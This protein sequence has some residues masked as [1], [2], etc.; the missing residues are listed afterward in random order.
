MTS[1]SFRAQGLTSLSPSRLSIRGLAATRVSALRPLS[2][3]AIRETRP[4]TQSSQ[5]PLPL[6]HS[7]G[8]AKQEGTIAS[9]FA[10]LSGGS[11]DDKLPPRF[12]ELKKSMVRDDRHK[13]ALKQAWLDVLSRLERRVEETK[14][15]G[16]KTIPEVN[17]PGDANIL[18]PVSEWVSAENLEQIKDRGVVVVKGVVP[19][20]QALRWK[21]EIREYVNRN[22]QVKGFPEDNPQVYELYWSKPQLEA[23][24]NH[25]LLQT[26][27]TFLS[28]FHAPSQGAG[29]SSSGRVSPP[30]LSVSLSNPLT[31]ADRLRIRLP[32]DSKFALG[33]HIDGGG[34]E[35]WECETFRGVWSSILEGGTGWARHD[36]WSLGPSAERLGAKTDMYGGPGQCAVFRPLQGW[37]SMSYTRSNEGTLRVLPFLKES[38][39]YIIL[40]PFFSPKKKRSKTG[41]PTVVIAKEDISEEEYLSAENWEFDSDSSNFPGCSLGHNIELSDSTHPHLRLGE[42]MTSIP[43]VE[44]GDMVLW[45]C[46][47]VHSVEARH[48]GKGDSS[49]MYIP[50]IPTTKVN[51]DYVLQ[52]SRDFRRGSPP[53][54]FPG[55]QGE[56]YFDGRG[57]PEDIASPMARR[58]MAL[59]KFEIQD[60]MSLAE[61]NLLD[62]CNALIR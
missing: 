39:A 22:P 8:S 60:G 36:P 37:L 46:D 43:K 42:T 38:T 50:A 25:A 33:P 40:R 54:D 23:R 48:C 26:S 20:E 34:V 62:Y 51:F 55:G 2:T 31:Y 6:K 11:L 5:A 7:N 27:R 41:D 16:P 17:Y 19:Q 35:R 45:H 29:A 1:V 44:P 52:Q 24:G 9:V 4:S 58:A 57:R 13:R 61:R 53:P 56:S 28:L 32:G 12:S 49:V 59:E 10:S 3:D 18:K 14:K 47:Q 21:Q 30:S 15:L